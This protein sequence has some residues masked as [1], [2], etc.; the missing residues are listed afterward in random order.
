[1]YLHFIRMT[2]T[3]YDLINH[4][5]N[6]SFSLYQCHKNHAN[7]NLYYSN[8]YNIIIILITAF[9]GTASLSLLFEE[10]TV[11]KAMNV[12]LSYTVVVLGML[13]K[14]YNPVKKYENH[15]VASDSYISLYYEIRE[16]I[17]FNEI[18]ITTE[19]VEWTK[20]VNDKLDDYRKTSPYIQDT[21]YDLYKSLYIS[22]KCKGKGIPSTDVPLV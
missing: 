5:E 6:V 9:T 1:M 2:R 11:L 13:Q 17:T 20:L 19:I 4:Y 15:R 18:K 3:I 7:N 16:Y 22:D 14:N 12:I 10:Y 21:D 8:L